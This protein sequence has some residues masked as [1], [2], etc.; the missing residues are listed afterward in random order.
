MG[1]ACAWS[2]LC[3]TVLSFFLVLRFA[4]ILLMRREGEREREREGE[5]GVLEDG[6]Y[7]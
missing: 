2:L 4:V 6:N 7:N 5:R 3:N 1:G